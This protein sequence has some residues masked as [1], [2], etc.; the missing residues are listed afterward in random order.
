M[1]VFIDRIIPQ[2]GLDLLEEAGIPYEQHTANNEL[3]KAALI[4]KCQAHDALLTAGWGPLDQ[5]FLQAC[6]HL[7]VI[8]LHSVGYDRIDIQEATRLKIPVG[9]TPDVLSEATAD[10][11]FLLMLAVSRKALFLHKK[12]IEGK[13]GFSQPTDDLGFS[14][15]GKTLGIFGLGNIGY[16]LARKAKV[17]FNMPIIY[18]NRSSNQK[19]EQELGAKRVSFEE[20]VSQSDVLAAFSTLTAE[21]RHKFNA[22]VFAKM[23]PSAIFINASRGS[24][25]H[26]PDLIHAIQ[27]GQIWGAGLDVTDPE[28]MDKDNP[29]L[30]MPTVAVFPHIGSATREARDGMATI[31][32]KNIIAASK[33][34]RLP[35]L[36]NPEAYH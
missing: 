13:W 28:P 36:V 31:A 4:E 11:A 25:H 15:T 33:G 35:Y 6:K 27:T 24:V 21:T 1:T 2:I 12:I 8:A 16:E 32:A 18:H 23:K 19:A 29:L 9:N 14:L 3:S 5:E 20:L 7:K 22:S 30:A 26:E 17:A 10:T 34:E